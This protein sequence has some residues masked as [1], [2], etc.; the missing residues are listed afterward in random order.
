MK[1]IVGELKY[2]NQ[3]QYKLSNNYP[4]KVLAAVASITISENVFT[5]VNTIDDRAK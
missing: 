5:A 3:R 2:R 1:E 4:V